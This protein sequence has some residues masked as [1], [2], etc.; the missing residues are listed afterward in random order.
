M[1]KLLNTLYITNPDHYLA[2]DG[3]TVSV[4]NNDEVI[5]RLPLHN[6]KSIVTFG[7]TGASPALMGA[8]AKRNI[9]LNFLTPSGRFLARIIGE[10]RGNVVLRKQQYRI[11][12]SEEK[13]LCYCQK[14]CL[15]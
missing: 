5:A 6:L 12:D 7:Y 3:E 14:F 11:S 9:D 2:L 10:S 4:R 1:K 8:C 15:G 13:K